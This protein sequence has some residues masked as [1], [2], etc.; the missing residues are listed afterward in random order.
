MVFPLKNIEEH[1]LLIQSLWT[2]W[3]YVA[4]WTLIGSNLTVI[5]RMLKALL[6]L[7]SIL[8]FKYR[9]WMLTME[10]THST[11]VSM[12]M[13]LCYNCFNSYLC[14]GTEHPTQGTYI[15]GQRLHHAPSLQFDFQKTQVSVSI[16][17]KQ[18]ELWAKLIS[19]KLPGTLRFYYYCA[20]SLHTVTSM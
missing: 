15:V 5:M 1:S 2:L 14:C 13:L 10:H 4:C 8:L 16:H 11:E 18:V 12:L 6:C 9:I 3:Y 20:A 7:W 19:K 17:D